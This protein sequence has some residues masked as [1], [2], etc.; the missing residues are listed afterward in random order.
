LNVSGSSP[1]VSAVA[2]VPDAPEATWHPARLIPVAG[3]KGQKEQEQRATSV[4]LAV[5][6]AVPDFGH[7]LLAPLGAPRGRIRSF[8]EVQFRKVDGQLD[9]PDGAVVVERGGKQWRAIVEVKT[10]GAELRDD[11]VDRYLDVAREHG[12][13]AVLTISNQITSSVDE[14]PCSLDRRKLKRVR[15]YH[16]SWW[17]IVTEAVLQHRF[18]GIK[19]PDQAWILGELIAYLDHENAGA[20]GFED[21]G[22]RWVKVREA[23]RQGTLRANDPEVRVI[24][25]RWEHFL[26]YLALGLSQDLGREVTPVRPRKQTTAERVDGLVQQLAT[27]AQLTGGLRVPDAIAPLDV[28]VDLRARQ[29]TT[30]VRVDGPSTGRPLTR[31]QWML[32]QLREAPGDLRVDA[33]FANTR[34]TTSLLLAEAQEFPERALF[35]PDKRRDPRAFVIAM[36]RPMG[37]KRGKVKGSFVR[38]TRRQVLDFYGTVVQDLKPWQPK[39]PQLK[40]QDEEVPPTAQPDPPPFAAVDQR[41]IGE[42]ID[43]EAAPLG[44]PSGHEAEPE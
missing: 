4:L 16:L 1:R 30:S 43:P 27:T 36:S 14:S 11:Q 20:G 8:G 15:V 39:P 12:F 25:Q 22:E 7:A 29:V 21:M 2:A 10:G 42:G 37:A 32:R 44:S 35:G 38:E 28:R 24:A 31:V 33:A 18:R 9:T 5:M 23:A 40:Q 34:D 17:R 41:D 3:I 19:D 26:D 6:G 13:D